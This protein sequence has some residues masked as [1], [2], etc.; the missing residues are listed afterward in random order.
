MSESRPSPASSPVPRRGAPAS[1]RRRSARAAVDWPVDVELESGRVRG[2]LRDVSS[3]G[4]CLFVD[5]PIPEMSVLALNIQ[6]GSRPL[7][8]RGAVVRCQRVSPGL[9]HYEVAIFFHEIAPA[10]RLSIERHVA[11][12]TAR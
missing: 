8:A 12:A 5:R 2:R 1:D 11:L 4:L 6:F 7:L 10:D 9:E 3:S